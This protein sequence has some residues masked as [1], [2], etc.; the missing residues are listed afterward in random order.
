MALLTIGPSA[1]GNF[2]KT[3]RFRRGFVRRL[4]ISDTLSPIR[5]VADS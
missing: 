4:I 5:K 1:A 3:H 2:L